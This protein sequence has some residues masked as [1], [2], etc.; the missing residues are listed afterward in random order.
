MDFGVNRPI[1]G[2][3]VFADFSRFRFLKNPENKVKEWVSS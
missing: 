2:A 1:I 3:F